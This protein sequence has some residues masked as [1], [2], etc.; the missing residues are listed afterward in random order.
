MVHF[1]TSVDPP[2]TIY[3]GKDKVENEDLIK[4]AW[5]QDVWFHVDKLSSA[6]VSPHSF[7]IGEFNSVSCSGKDNINNTFG[8][9]IW[10][11]GEISPSLHLIRFNHSQR[12]FNDPPVYAF[13]KATP[14]IAEHA[15]KIRYPVDNINGPIQIFPAYPAYVFVSDLIGGSTSLKT[16]NIFPGRQVNGS[17]ITTADGDPFVGQLSVYGYWN[18]INAKYPVKLAILNL[19]IYNSTATYPR[20][21]VTVERIWH[22]RGKGWLRGQ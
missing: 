5:P 20:P 6:H 14:S 7:M 13:T 16:A 1:F 18:H 19:E 4:Y 9:A 22:T 11:V 15:A 3:M 2:A 21:N 12:W 10:L 8:Q 17:S